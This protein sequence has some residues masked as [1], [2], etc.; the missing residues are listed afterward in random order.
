[1]GRK[2]LCLMLM[3]LALAPCARAETPQ[4][5]PQCS[6]R[7]EVEAWVDFGLE[8]ADDGIPSAKEVE[9][10]RVRHI[11]QDIAEDPTFVGWYWLGGEEGGPLDLTQRTYGV[12]QQ[13]KYY[14]GNMCTRAVYSM[15]LSYLG[16]DCTPGDMSTLMGTRNLEEP[17]DKVTQALESVERVTFT[18]YIFDQMYALYEQDSSY[19]P[20]YMYF[21]KSTGATHAL[22]IVARTEKENGFWVVDPAGNSR[23]GGKVHVFRIR[24]NPV[25]KKIIAATFEKY[26]DST[27]VCF[28]QW[29]RRA[30]E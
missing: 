3:I 20:V 2:V 6:T 12:G 29:R 9:A 7:E 19:S 26:V 4:A 11:A 1:M 16:V 23:D 8:E 17:Y 25:K 15:A 24:F 5:L 28:C 13:Y 14:C 30:Q 18:Q 22:L 10:G 27:V 21:R